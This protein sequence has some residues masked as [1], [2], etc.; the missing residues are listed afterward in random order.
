MHS[1]Y[2]KWHHVEK[3]EIILKKFLKL[4]VLP[5]SVLYPMPLW[6]GNYRTKSH[7]SLFLLLHYYILFI[8]QIHICRCDFASNYLSIY[9]GGQPSNERKMELIDKLCRPIENDGL[10]RISSRQNVQLRFITAS[11]HAFQVF[12]SF[13]FPFNHC[14]I[15]NSSEI[16]ILNKVLI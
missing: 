15:C 10:L 1:K 7:S 16:S 9:E 11:N 13:S 6:E 5:V 8:C 14:T 4:T 2:F 12:L 3:V